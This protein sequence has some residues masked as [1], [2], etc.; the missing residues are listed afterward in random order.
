MCSRPREKQECPQ[1]LPKLGVHRARAIMAS[2]KLD[3]PV[4]NARV[5][6]RHIRR[7]MCGQMKSGKPPYLNKQKGRK[8]LQDSAPANWERQEEMLSP[9]NLKSE[10]PS[11]SRRGKTFARR[12]CRELPYSLRYGQF[13][14]GRRRYGWIANNPDRKR[15][16]FYECGRDRALARA[17]PHR[18]NESFNGSAPPAPAAV[19][20]FHVF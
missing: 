11:E 6:G 8:A 19:S 17:V 5:F 4:K 16:R 1:R 9:L 7:A 3:F 13:L 18:A 10:N 15:N 12:L 2:L 20:D 14:S